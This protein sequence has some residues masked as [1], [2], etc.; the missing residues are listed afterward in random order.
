MTFSEKITEMLEHGM[1]ASMELA[2]KAG[3]KAQDLGEKGVL[4]MEKKQC[5]SKAQKLFLRLGSAVYKILI[6]QGVCN[7][8]KDTP[9]INSIL[10]EISALRDIIEKNEEN[11]KN[12]Q[13]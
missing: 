12:R 2:I 1:A 7:V 8:A 10:I 5:E 4:M 13:G 6:E 3:S 11:L 9:E